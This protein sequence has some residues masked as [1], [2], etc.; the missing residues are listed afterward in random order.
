MGQT[1]LQRLRTDVCAIP[2]KRG[3]QELVGA[4]QHYGARAQAGAEALEA[5]ANSEKWVRVVFP[6][7]S[8]ASHA[9]RRKASAAAAKLADTVRA[10]AGAVNDAGVSAAFATLGDHITGAQKALRDPWTRQMEQRLKGFEALLGAAEAAGLP[11]RHALAAQI[12]RLRVQARMPPADEET[13]RGV[14]DA[15][16]ELAAVV[17]RLGLG[18]AAGEFLVGA[19]GSH[20]DPRALADPEVRAFLDRHSLW[21]VLVVSFR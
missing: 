16:T 19:A 8:T 14:A 7:L 5:T 20:G 13:A 12:T 1:R 21:E 15:F 3:R 18:G 17:G 4:L 6:N 10:G 9:H 2:D 11:G